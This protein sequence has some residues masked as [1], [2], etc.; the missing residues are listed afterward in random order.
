VDLKSKI[1]QVLA[2]RTK[3]RLTTKGL[4]AAAVLIPIF[5][6]EGEYYILLTKRTETVEKHKG[7]PCF[8]GGASHS[9][10]A[11]LIDTALRETWEEIG[12]KPEN[13][14]LLGEFDEIQT[15]TTFF[16]ITPFVGMIPCPYSF[17]I[18]HDE[19]EEIIEVPISALRDPK[20]YWEETRTY[21]GQDFPVSHFKYGDHVIWGATARMLK[22]FLAL[23]F[24]DVEPGSPIPPISRY[25]TD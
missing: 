23:L 24:E 12:L 7:Q 4:T 19:V 8:P 5:E 6:R 17:N 3:R 14:E 9:E 15:P 1:R 18:N 20:N 10:D 21:V 16:H 22:D 13:V 2:H 11:S 25:K